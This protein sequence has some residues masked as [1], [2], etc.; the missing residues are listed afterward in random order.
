MLQLNH[1]P[2][3][4]SP[5]LSVVPPLRLCPFTFTALLPEASTTSGQPKS[6]HYPSLDC[7]LCLA[8]AFI[9]CSNLS[10]LS[11]SALSSL[12]RCKEEVI[13]FIFDGDVGPNSDSGDL[14]RIASSSN[15][16]I[17]GVGISL[18]ILLVLLALMLLKLDPSF[19]LLSLFVSE[20]SGRCFEGRADRRRL[21]E[22]RGGEA[23]LCDSS[24]ALSRLLDDVEEVD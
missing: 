1:F 2:C 13:S 14:T 19:G 23:V 18:F 16:K 5:L 11:T 12:F 24:F 4:I 20:L 21:R 7:F 10:L 8:S 9:A 15:T 17:E 22:A 3:Y 6:S